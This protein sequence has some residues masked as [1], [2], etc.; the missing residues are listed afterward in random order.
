MEYQHRIV[1]ALIEQQLRASGALLIR[2]VKGS[3]KTETGRHHANSE[4]A[5]DASPAIVNAMQ[6][7][8]GFLL[9]G[10]TPRL[11]DEW[12][13]QPVLWNTI[14]HE[15]DNRKQKG[16]FILTGS[17]NPEETANLHSGVGRFGVIRMRTMTWYELGWSNGTMSLRNLLEGAP[18]DSEM[19]KADLPLTASRLVT[20]GWPG[21]LGIGEESAILNMQNYFEL[22]TEVDLSRVSGVRRDPVKIRRSLQSIAR[23][24]ATECA[25]STIA[26]DAGDTDNPLANDTVAAY[27]NALNRLMIA[28]DLPAWSPKIRSRARLRNSPKRHLADPSLA[29]AALGLDSRKLLSDLE[30]F[31]LLFESSVIHDLR[32]YAESAGGRLY[33]YRDSNGVEADAILENR[34]GSWV[35]FE[36]KLGFGGAEQGAESLQRLKRGIDT[37]SCGEPLALIVVTGS[38]FAH[39]RND[40]VFVIPFQT[41]RP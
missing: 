7:D 34:D 13:E 26:K 8:P 38:G 27:L 25:I 19:V 33:H 17:A 6:S 18:V 28:D 14:R 29:A 22:L 30:Y 15:V 1:D 2:G 10:E 9:R 37:K 32:I 39:K 31:G 35:A 11:I 40:G 3:G 12:Q 5:I 21:N 16:Q 4:I 23:N 20:G 24:I 36:I 41:L